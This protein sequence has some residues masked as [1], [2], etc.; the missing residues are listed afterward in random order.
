MSEP[1]YTRQARLEEVGEKGQARLASGEAR[2]AGAGLAGV[3]AARYAAGAGFG[4]LRVREEHAARAARA[5]DARV[6]TTTDPDVTEDAAPAWLDRLDPAARA[7][8]AGA[9]EALVAIVRRLAP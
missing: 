2:I 6:R 3:V 1:R 5:V 7:V 8:A 4:A 9:H